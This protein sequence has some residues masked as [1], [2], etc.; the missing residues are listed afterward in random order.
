MSAVILSGIV[1]VQ[2]S[3]PNGM[4][5]ANS[6]KYGC[7]TLAG[8][9][10]GNQFLFY[11]SPVSHEVQVTLDCSCPTKCCSIWKGGDIGDC[12]IVNIRSGQGT[13]T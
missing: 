7:G 2:G 12:T 11:C 8:Y 9:N 5:C 13:S 6:G 4:P 10:N 1:T 3:N